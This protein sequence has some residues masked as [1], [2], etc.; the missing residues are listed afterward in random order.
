VPALRAITIDLL[1][2]ELYVLLVQYGHDVPGWMAAEMASARTGSEAAVTASARRSL[3]RRGLIADDGN[4]VEPVRQLLGF[5]SSPE[6]MVRLGGTAPDHPA[7][8][9][10]CKPEVSVEHGQLAGL[11]RF[12][13][14][15]TQD[16]LVHVG[17]AAS[18]ATQRAAAGPAFTAPRALL[19]DLLGADDAPAAQRLMDAGVAA[20]SAVGFAP[21]LR[22]AGGAQSLE[23]TWLSSPRVA[24][25]GQL[26]WVNGGDDGVWQLDPGVVLG[27][28]QHNASVAPISASDLLSELAS[29]LPGQA[30]S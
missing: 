16:L 4:V 28:G 22:N 18:L 30:A 13:V 12:V 11:H 14:L 9:F 21:A 20:E 10:L 26:A 2:D 8:L 1:A 29:Y 5:V 27:G 15:P 3:W 6:L 17:R 25:G 24:V 7:R 19:A 23:T